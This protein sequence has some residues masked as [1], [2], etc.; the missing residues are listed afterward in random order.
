MARIIE[1]EKGKRRVIRMST[2]D[3]LSVVREYQ[4][5]VRL[6]SSYDEIRNQLDDCIIF[7]PEDV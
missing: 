7:V 1:N 4:R 2:D 3:V 6:R 5:H